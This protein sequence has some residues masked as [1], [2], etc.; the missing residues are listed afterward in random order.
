VKT[1]TETR[2]P[3][4]FNWQAA[5]VIVALGVTLIS[6]AGGQEVTTTDGACGF[7]SSAAYEG[8]HLYNSHKQV[9]WNV[10]DAADAMKYVLE[11]GFIDGESVGC[12]YKFEE[13][14]GSSGD[15]GETF[16][17]I[18]ATCKSSWSVNFCDPKAYISHRTQTTEYEYQLYRGE[19]SG[20]SIKE[21]ERKVQP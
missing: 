14:G 18:T 9:K 21:S 3:R 10:S 6:L 4:C 5:L 8:H 17:R 15:I 16:G 20:I 13:M 7:D 2:I 1:W 11:N 19:R 12:S